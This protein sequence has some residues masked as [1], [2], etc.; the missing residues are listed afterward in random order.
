[1]I[2]VRAACILAAVLAS[3]TLGSAQTVKQEQKPA[4]DQAMMT[5]GEHAMG[6]DQMATT[7]HFL[8]QKEGGAI[9]ITAKDG[10][11]RTAVAS[12]RKHLLHIQEAFGK[13]DFSLPIFIHA[14]EP[15]GAS[16]LREKREQMTYQYE[17]IADGGRLKIRTA[18]RDAMAALHAFLRYQITEHKTGDPLEPK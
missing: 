13:G 7:H 4:H 6:F 3:S 10:N 16:V 5:R 2:S 8:L 17:E 9:E 14:T 11:D 15:P 18:D 12:I 1:M